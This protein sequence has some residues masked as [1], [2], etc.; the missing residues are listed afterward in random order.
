MSSVC[1]RRPPR[2][3]V[4]TCWTFWVTSIIYLTHSRCSLLLTERTMML[5]YLETAAFL[6]LCVTRL[7]SSCKFNISFLYFE[8]RLWAL[9]LLILLIRFQLFQQTGLKFLEILVKILLS[10]I[11][12]LP[13][14]PT[15]RLATAMPPS[16]LWESI[17]YSASIYCDLNKIYL[18]SQSAEN[19]LEDSTALNMVFVLGGDTYDGDVTSRSQLPGLVDK[20]WGAGYKNDGTDHSFANIMY[21]FD[22][23]LAKLAIQF[24]V[25]VSFLRYLLVIQSHPYSVENDRNEMGSAWRPT[26]ARKLSPKN[27]EDPGHAELG[28]RASGK[29]FYLSLIFHLIR[30]GLVRNFAVNAFHSF[31][32]GF[33]A[34]AR[35]HI[36]GV[37]PMC[38]APQQQRKC[39][40]RLQSCS[41]HPSHNTLQIFFSPVCPPTGCAGG[42]SGGPDG[43]YVV[44]APPPRCSGVQHGGRDRQHEKALHHRARRPGQ[45]V[46]RIARRALNWRNNR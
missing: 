14:D 23:F 19:Q 17:S 16:T 24:F 35:H 30:N 31:S 26:I 33:I 21:R 40:F 42:L 27:P 18:L 32:S 13:I 2:A 12:Q 9:Q 25:P 11:I 20:T 4:E 5:N 1:N 29:H 38:E 37:Y 39:F 15:G 6:F 41:I 7:V 10:L 46:R 44:P 34:P 28:N 45:R 22:L 3:H 43:Y 8:F 36:C